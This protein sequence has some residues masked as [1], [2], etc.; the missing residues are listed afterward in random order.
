MGVIEAQP[1]DPDGVHLGR[2]APWL[3]LVGRGPSKEHVVLSDGWRRIR[4][5]VDHGSLRGT[6]RVRLHYRLSG[7]VD[8]ER[9]LL[10]LRRLLGLYRHGRFTS[11]LFPTEP[12]IAR[13]LLCLRVSDGLARGASQR[14]I[15]IALHGEARIRRDWHPGSALHARIRRLTRAARVLADGGYRSLMLGSSRLP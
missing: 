7:I 14:D 8:A 15:A 1:D 3:T 6:D 13:W 5:D 9:R 2:L 10:T 4:L 12:R 11:R